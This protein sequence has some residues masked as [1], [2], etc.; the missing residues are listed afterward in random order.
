MTTNPKDEALRLARDELFNIKVLSQEISQ[1]S[2][3]NRCVK[4]IAAIAA[5]LSA[6]VAAAEPVDDQYRMTDDAD[7]VL[8][9]SVPERWKGCTSPIGAVQSYIAELEDA[10]TAR[11]IDLDALDVVAQAKPAGE[12]A[13]LPAYIYGREAGSNE[14]VW[15]EAAV[16]TLLAQGAPAAEREPVAVTNVIR[17]ARAAQN[18]FFEFISG[19]TATPDRVNCSEFGEAM[20]NLSDALFEMDNGV[21]LS[22]GEKVALVAPPAD[23]PKGW[24]PTHKHLKRGTLYEEVARG[25]LQTAQPLTDMMELVAYRGE[26]GVMWFRPVSEFDDDE[27]FALL[28]TPARA[29]TQ[30]TAPKGEAHE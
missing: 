4:T 1:W 18:Y 10:L 12:A 9:S 8:R 15:T 6:P 7:R 24:K 30:P 29:D 20:S 11:G 25:A 21:D 28:A 13:K 3:A 14:K 23:T 2:T 16:R 27:R 26:D 5:A 22:T 17:A 19:E